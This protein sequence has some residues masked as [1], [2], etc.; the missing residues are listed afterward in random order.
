MKHPTPVVIFGAGGDVVGRE[1]LPE[2]AGADDIAHLAGH[3]G[4][5]GL[6]IAAQE[7]F[8]EPVLGLAPQRAVEAR[9]YD[10]DTVASIGRL[11]D[12][13]VVVAGFARDRKSV[14]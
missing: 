3:V 7:T 13:A 1:G 6:R 10:D 5:V 8:V 4:A 11:T 14:V 2:F 9:E 12:E